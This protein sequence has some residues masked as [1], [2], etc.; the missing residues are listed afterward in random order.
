MSTTKVKGIAQNLSSKKR[1]PNATITAHATS[2]EGA[3]VEE[4]ALTVTTDDSGHFHFDW[5]VGEEVTVLF[6]HRRYIDLQSLTITVPE[7]GLVGL[8]NR[9]ALQVPTKIV[10]AVLVALLPVR[11]DDAACQVVVT[12]TAKDKTLDDDPQGEAGAITRLEPGVSQPFYAG[13]FRNGPLK[14]KTDV[15]P[16]DLNATSE[17]GGVFFFNVPVRAEAYEIIAEKSGVNLTSCR[18]FA[19]SNILINGAP[20][21]GPIVIS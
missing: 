8:H 17:D 20:P 15:F 1:I 3:F 6:S 14:L 13:I 19:R 16:Q 7:E 12:V 9:I 10:Y 21:N 18:F 4:A 2:A 5:P 11:A